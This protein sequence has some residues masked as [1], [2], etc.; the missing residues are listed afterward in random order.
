MLGRKQD[1][2]SYNIH[3]VSSLISVL[4]KWEYEKDSF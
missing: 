4:L 1:G 2:E 3:V